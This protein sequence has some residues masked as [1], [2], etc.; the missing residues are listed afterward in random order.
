MNINVIADFKIMVQLSIA[1]QL[2][3]LPQYFRREII[4]Q[5]SRYRNGCGKSKIFNVVS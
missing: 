5:F 1:E 2:I 3:C 4:V